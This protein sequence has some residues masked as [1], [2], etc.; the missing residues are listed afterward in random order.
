M[1]VRDAVD[2]DLIP[3]YSTFIGSVMGVDE[4]FYDE[5]A[6]R[7]WVNRFPI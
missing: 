7:D 4:K 5:Q 3:I 6:K 1:I 2:S